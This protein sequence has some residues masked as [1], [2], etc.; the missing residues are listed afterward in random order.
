MKTH[1]RYSFLTI[2]LACFVIMSLFTG[3]AA[4]DQYDM[5]IAPYGSIFS[6]D[7]SIGMSGADVAALQSMFEKLGYQTGG[8]DGYFGELTEAA[9]IAFQNRYGFYEPDGI[10]DYGVKQ[11]LNTV[12]SAI[13]GETGIRIYD[14]LLPTGYSYTVS[15][16]FA[17]KKQHTVILSSDSPNISI[18]G[19]NITGLASGSA[20]VCAVSDAGTVKFFVSVR[21]PE[22]IAERVGDIKYANNLNTGIEHRAQELASYSGNPGKKILFIGDCFL[23]ERLFLIDFEE[24]FAG[25]NVYTIALGGTTP[26]QWV[27]YLQYF[28][29][30]QPDAVLLSAGINNIRHG[31]T[32]ATAYYDLADLFKAIHMYMPNTTIYWWELMPHIGTNEDYYKTA[33]VNAAVR[34]YAETD[35]KLIVVDT[36]EAMTD[37]NGI[38][39]P[40]LYRDCLHANMAGYDE[41]FRATREAGLEW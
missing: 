18:S 6:R 21:D 31:E 1:S 36:Y 25:S 13:P 16:I 40:S 26:D 10:V 37:E 5:S 12:M 11:V 39:D 9:V 30:Y 23:D 14:M 2:I 33:A 20:E 34:A 32:A 19:M 15:P 41:M 3:T 35:D 28:Y 7:L 22:E 4:A 24:R 27:K 17:D 38:A 8:V 29:W